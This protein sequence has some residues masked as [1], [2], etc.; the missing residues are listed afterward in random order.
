MK[1]IRY[2]SMILLC[3]LAL[4]INSSTVNA[5]V[6]LGIGVRVHVTPPPLPVYEQPLCPGD[7]YLWVPGYWAWTGDEY[8]W[9]PGEWIEPPEDGYLWT[10]CYWGF[11]NGFYVFHR[12]YWGRNV[13]YY[14][15]VNYGYGYFGS[16]FYGG[17]W[18]GNRFEYNAAIMNVNRNRVHNIYRDPGVNRFKSNERASFNGPG[19]VRTRPNDQERLAMRERHIP[20]TSLQTTRQL[21]YSRD[22]NQF[23]SVNKGRPATTVM[24]SSAGGRG[25][26]HQ[27]TVQNPSLHNEG[28]NRNQ[29]QR[30]SVNRGE[31]HGA[32]KNMPV[33][34][35]GN[36]EG[37]RPI[38]NEGVRQQTHSNPSQDVRQSRPQ[39]HQDQSAPRQYQA[40]RQQREQVA[41]RQQAPQQRQQR[42]QMA[43]RQQEPRG[44]NREHER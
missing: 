2:L 24:N 11:T 4:C 37:N 25:L 29:N 15:G 21:Q 41:P 18:R 6:T 38:R 32:G 16:G 33:N 20:P 1:T 42:E 40:P 26:R 17:R 36:M 12:G 22:R 44:N 34:S 39:S 30:S 7:G 5:Q 3:M 27:S 28:V 43:P 23:S 31:Q 10:P 13:G 8:Y 35:Q 9:V 14:G 19:G